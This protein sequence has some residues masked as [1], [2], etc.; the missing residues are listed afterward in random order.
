[1]MDLGDI[2]DG[3]EV[4]VHKH[5]LGFHLVHVADSNK[6]YL[7]KSRRN[8]FEMHTLFHS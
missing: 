3:W 1:M 7:E 4:R 5:K 6:R 8:T 2:R